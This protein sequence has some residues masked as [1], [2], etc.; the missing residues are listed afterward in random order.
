MN[1]RDD[2]LEAFGT[3]QAGETKKVVYTVRAVT[4]GKFTLPPVEAEAMYDSDALG[5]RRGRHGRGERAVDRQAALARPCVCRASPETARRGAAAPSSPWL[6]RGRG[7]LSR[8]AAR[9]AGGAALGGRR[10]SRRHGPRTCSSRPT[11][12][13]ACP[14]DLGTSIR[15]T[16]ARWSRSRTSGSGRTTA[17]IRSRSCARVASN[18]TQGR[19]VSGGSTLS[20]QLARVL[21]AA[22]AHDPVEAHRHVPRG[23]ARR[24]AVQAR[25]PRTPTSRSHAVRR[26][27]RGRRGG[28]A[29]VLRAQRA[30]PDAASRSRRCSP[31]RRTPTGAS[32][33][34]RTHARLKTARDEVARK[35]LD[36]RRCRSGPPR[37]R[38]RRGRA[39]R[40]RNTPVPSA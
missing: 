9:A 16:S 36:E 14:V 25:D 32:P 6:R 27:R 21:R 28:G 7:G 40:V 30:A 17:S 11:T 5:A 1:M 22:A 20:M 39:R 15:P 38:P 24:A 23:P 3:L 35:L 19:R 33:R 12:S 34:R 4:A 10:V 26:E 2:H 29:G 37:P 31:C 8:A 13:G 18:V